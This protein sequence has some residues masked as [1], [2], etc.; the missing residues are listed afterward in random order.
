MF[1]GLGKLWKVKVYIYIALFSYGNVLLVTLSKEI[2]K[3][4]FSVQL[5]VSL[6]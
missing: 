3:I 5:S 4:V 6:A 2:E 1:G